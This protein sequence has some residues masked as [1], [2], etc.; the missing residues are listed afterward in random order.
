MITKI[1]LM[2]ADK[3]IIY[4]KNLLI[5]LKEDYNQKFLDEITLTAILFELGSA[6]DLDLLKQEVIQLSNKYPVLIE[7]TFKDK[8]L[9]NIDFLK[10]ISTSLQEKNDPILTKE[11]EN[12][13]ESNQEPK[14]LQAEIQKLI[15]KI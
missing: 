8:M 4:A 15:K 6:R 5:K 14:V 3:A 11:V 12:V 9:E 1:L 2:L 10:D 7:F 13:L